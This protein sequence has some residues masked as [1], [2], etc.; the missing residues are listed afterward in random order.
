[1][2]RELAST[3]HLES[4]RAIPTLEVDGS[5]RGKNSASWLD[6]T[7]TSHLMD[8]NTAQ[9][10]SLELV[11]KML[12]AAIDAV[13][14]EVIVD[15][16]V[17]VEME[18]N[19][20]KGV[21]L[22]ERGLLPA[23][24]VIICLGPWSSVA[25]ED[26]FGLPLPME[27]IKSTS[28]VFHDV[29]SMR[30]EPFACFCSEDKNGCHLEL[31]PRPN[32]DLYVCGIGGSD[33]VSGD[34]LRRD[35]DC[36]R[37]ERVREDPLRVTAAL[38]SLSH[39][40]SVFTATQTPDIAQACMRPCTSDGLPVMGVIPGVKGGFISTG[41]NCWGILWAPV[42]GL[43]MAELVATGAAKVI[44]LS[45]FDPSRYMN[46]KQGRGKKKGV[47]LLGEQW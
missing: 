47:Q 29:S 4:Y 24:Q 2:H 1:M 23:D 39:L 7:V 9:V 36:G 8:D 16:A 20:I 35:G 46:A 11:E 6:R 32:G 41:H 3:L 10:T 31:Y 25:V 30:E 40:S 37:A 18:N 34:R 43:A 27:G 19:E 5:R 33:Y 38:S 21:H 28:I 42:C 17:G 14:V 22:Q 45:A 44:D 13:G 12:Q 15:S 26:W